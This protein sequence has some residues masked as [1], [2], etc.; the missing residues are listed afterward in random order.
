MNANDL[1]KAFKPTPY[2]FTETLN[3]TLHGLEEVPTM[4]KITTRTVLIVAL[5]TALT[6]GIVYAAVSYGQQWYYETRFTAF[7]EHRPDVYKEVIKAL[8][9]NIKQENIGDGAKVVDFKVE[10]SAWVENSDIFTLSFT[11]KAVDEVENEL[12]GMMEMDVDGEDREEHWLWTKKGCGVPKDVMED[13]NK[14]LILIDVFSY[15]NGL[16][17]GNSGVELPIS[18]YDVFTDEEGVVFIQVEANLDYIKK[19]KNISNAINETLKDSML[20][21]KMLYQVYYFKDNAFVNPVEGELIF[22]VKVK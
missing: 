8:D 19:D 16:K 10:D 11:A 6:L 4:K 17:I 7:E 5:I 13:P 2:I 15:E 9:N 21:L 22:E 12:H 20:M 18:S 3:K 14:Q 1:D